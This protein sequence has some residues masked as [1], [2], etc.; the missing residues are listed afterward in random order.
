MLFVDKNG[1]EMRRNGPFLDGLHF[2]EAR[3][4]AKHAARQSDSVAAVQGMVEELYI[5]MV[6]AEADYEDDPDAA[7]ERHL[8][9]QGYEE[10]RA[11]EAREQAMDVVPFA[12]QLAAARREAEKE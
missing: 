10:A 11:D 4:L 3:E 1:A 8:E 9:D 7:Y 12:D 2:G 6:E 5:D